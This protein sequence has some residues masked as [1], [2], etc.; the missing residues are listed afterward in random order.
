MGYERLEDV[1]LHSDVPDL[2]EAIELGEDV[3]ARDDDGSN[4][5]HTTATLEMPE[6]TAMLV[7]AGA[8][9]GAQDAAGRTPLHLALQLGDEET[10]RILVEAGA[11]LDVED[12]HGNRPLVKALAGC[13]RE[14]LAF[15]VAEGANPRHENKHGVS[16]WGQAAEHWDEVP[17][18]LRE[19]ADCHPPSSSDPDVT[20][21][22]AGHERVNLDAEDVPEW[23]WDNLVPLSGPADTVQGELLRAVETLRSE[24]QR[25]GNGNWG[26]RFEGHVDFLED[27]LCDPALFDESEREATHSDLARLRDSEY[28][29]YL[30]DD[31]YDRLVERVVAYCEHNPELIEVPPERRE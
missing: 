5:L 2:E 3:D 7:E 17:D 31:L 11:P 20:G 1:V 8:D 12:E 19:A 16:L 15:L 24:A 4:V 29:P 22:E 9:P 14:M 25:N 26:P 13:S 28:S 10:A 21:L 18:W 30:D 6:R 27:H 23:I